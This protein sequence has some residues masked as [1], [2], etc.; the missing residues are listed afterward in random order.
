MLRH[1]LVSSEAAPCRCPAQSRGQTPSRALGHREPRHSQCMPPSLPVFLQASIKPK[2]GRMVSFSSGGE[3][4]H[5]VKAVTK[6]QRCA[7]ALWFTLDPLYRE[8]VSLSSRCDG[9]GIQ[10][11]RSFQSHSISTHSRDV[12]IQGGREELLGNLRAVFSAGYPGAQPAVQAG[13]GCCMGCRAECRRAVCEA[14][15]VRS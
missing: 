10:S 1:F 3:N 2:C 7:V 11:I 9:D 14:G 4:P 15:A 8:L 12:R 6:G 13:L 5:G